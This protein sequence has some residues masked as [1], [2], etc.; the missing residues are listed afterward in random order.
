M[1]TGTKGL[2][3]FKFIYK[4]E[5]L[6]KDGQFLLREGQTRI[7][8]NIKYILDKLEDVDTLDLTTL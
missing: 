4:P 5:Y 6:R 2:V 7:V 1:R 8:G 3:V